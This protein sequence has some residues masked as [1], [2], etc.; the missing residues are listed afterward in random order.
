MK[1][2]PSNPD[3]RMLRAYFSTVWMENRPHIK[4]RV[5]GEFMHGDVCITLK[6]RR[7]GTPSVQP[8]GDSVILKTMKDCHGAT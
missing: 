8:T 3:K 2:H 1:V 5:G 7:H 4:I 6:E